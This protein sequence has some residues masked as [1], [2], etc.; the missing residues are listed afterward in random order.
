MEGE[1]LKN[2]VF[3]SAYFSLRMSRLKDGFNT[4]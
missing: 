2:D 4:T 1:A 3:S